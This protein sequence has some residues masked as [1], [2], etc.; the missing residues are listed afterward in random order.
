VA[1]RI[2]CLPIAVASGTVVHM[3][4]SST[5]ITSARDDGY[6]LY[7]SSPGRI[8]GSISRDNLL[9]A[10][11]TERHFEG[12]PYPAPGAR[13]RG[14]GGNPPWLVVDHY[15][16]GIVVN[17]WPVRLWRVAD[18]E[19]APPE[20][21]V[22]DWYTR[23]ISVGIV[24]EVPAWLLF[25]DHGYE[26][27]RVIDAA[28]RL[29]GG[30][31]MSLAAARP[32]TAGQI[33]AESWRRWL[34]HVPSGSPVGH[35]LLLIHQAVERSARRTGLPLFRYDTIDEVEVLADSTW[36]AAGRACLEAALGLGAPHLVDPTE[37]ALLTQAWRSWLNLS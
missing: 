33:Y 29:E 10:P 24:E 28:A 12:P 34:P 25:G 23:V 31:A 9:K 6:A 2:S 5:S 3:T 22:G 11:V 35:A 18:I 8:N 20:S 26:V 16:D 15:I 7:Q 17:Q 1:E 14:T 36:V 19:P 30:D 32:E 27:T 37:Q 4:A 13:V 21:Q